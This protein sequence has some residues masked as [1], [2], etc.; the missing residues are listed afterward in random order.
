MIGTAHIKVRPIKLALLVEPGNAA[1]VRKAIRLA[2]CFWGGAFFPIVVM[3][4]RAPNSWRLD[5]SSIPRANEVVMG[6]IDAFDPDFLVQL[7]DSVPSCIQEGQRKVLKLNDVWRSPQIEGLAE[8]AFGISALDVLQGIYDEHFKYKAKYP[9]RITIPSIPKNFGLFWACLYGEL[10]PELLRVVETQFSEPLEIDYINSSPEAFCATM[11]ASVLFPRR[12]TGWGL[13][14]FWNAAPLHDEDCVFLMDGG[15]LEDVVDFWN[16]RATGRSIFP[17]PKQFLQVESVFDAVVRFLRDARRPIRNDPS[18]HH[19]A[20]IFRSRNV[21]IEALNEFAGTLAERVRKTDATG[22]Q[23]FYLQNWH[24]I[25]WH[26]R[27][28]RTPTSVAD[29]YSNEE[30]TIDIERTSDNTIRLR[31]L[32]PKFLRDEWYRSGLLCANEFDFRIYRSDESLAEVY[33]KS[34][35]RKFNAAI[36]SIAGFRD[37]WRVGR[38]GLV[39]LVQQRA[40]DRLTI[41]TSERLFFAWLADHGWNAEL[42]GPGLLA[43]QIYRQLK[44][45]PGPLINASVLSLIEHMNGGAVGKDGKPARKATLSAERQMPVGE[46]K[47]R[48]KEPH[49]NSGLYDFLLERGVFKLGLEAKCPFCLRIS[50]YAMSALTESIECPKCLGSFAAAGNVDRPSSKWSYRTSGPFSI[51]NYAE[52][53][54]TV[55]LSMIALSERVSLSFRATAVPS[56]TAKSQTKGQLEADFALFW[57]ETFAGERNEGLLFGECKTYGRF[58]RRD[59]DRMRHLGDTFP[60][61]VLA[62]CTLRRSLEPK[63][64][65]SLIQLLKTEAKK[66]EKGRPFSPVLILTG[67]ELLTWERPPECW[68]EEHRKRFPLVYEILS[69]CKATQ[70]IHLGIT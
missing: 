30:E 58:E 25:N 62:F 14:R 43:K 44:G 24:P 34:S 16:L 46:V 48:L 4:R 50:W 69:L 41:P 45:H 65:R 19:V 15:S 56:F 5:S 21:A 35:G 12:I 66:S 3:H 26:E 28:R 1:Q 8:P 33:P 22:A 9:P 17:F 53:A 23:L 60:G 55:L 11:D 32:L 10:E 61:A 20:G 59:F 47:V 51:P 57:Q 7:A 67:T 37:D 29:I 52:G 18:N 31:P 54:Y 49:G 2:S 13:Q 38:H 6:Q 36:S 70:Y 39:K 27:A 68:P 40:F 42:S 64:I 63:E